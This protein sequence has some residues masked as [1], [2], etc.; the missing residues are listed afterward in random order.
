MI[1][2]SHI[3]YARRQVGAMIN[4]QHLLGQK[5][6]LVKLMRFDNKKRPLFVIEQMV[7]YAIGLRKECGVQTMED[8]NCKI[9]G[10]II[11]KEERKEKVGNDSFTWRIQ[12]IE[13]ELKK[14][15]I[16]L[17]FVQ[18]I[19]NPDSKLTEGD[20]CEF[21][22]YY[23][24]YK[25]LKEKNECEMEGWVYTLVR[26][27]LNESIITDIKAELVRREMEKWD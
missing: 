22:S 5:E 24:V 3:S 7:G 6:Y 17:M 26:D 21:A 13:K 8:K 4:L 12:I 1:I 19:T 27:N 23:K 25:E 10:E 16:L 2:I 14:E 15:K 20:I 11:L 9:L 18:N